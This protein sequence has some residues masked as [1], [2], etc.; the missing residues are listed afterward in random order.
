[1]KGTEDRLR[2]DAQ[3]LLG[4][5]GHKKAS[6]SLFFVSDR[7]METMKQRLSEV[8]SI[9]GKETWKKKK[10]KVTEVLSFPEPLDFPH[11]EVL[12]QAQD[13]KFLGE[14][15][16][17]RLAEKKGH[18]HL[19]KLLVHAIL[20]LLGYRHDKRYDTI[21]M[22]SKEKELLALLDGSS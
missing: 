7:D 9:R 18:D 5:L 15:Y 3:V 6:L 1:M 19:R 21:E 11:P 20:H 22:E 2:R 10:E 8:P 4:L 16:L 12:R 14:I 13:E 17:N